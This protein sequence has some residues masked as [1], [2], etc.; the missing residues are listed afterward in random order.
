M[1]LLHIKNHVWETRTHT[2]AYCHLHAGCQ[3]I[4]DRSFNT[5]VW[6]Y[7]PWENFHRGEILSQVWTSTKISSM[8]ETNSP[9]IFHSQASVSFHTVAIFWQFSDVGRIFQS[10]RVCWHRVKRALNSIPMA[11]KS[12]FPF[13]YLMRVSCEAYPAILGSGFRL[14]PH[15]SG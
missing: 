3:S 8:F 13:C 14:L 12:L 4:D 11:Y 6:P 1:H 5:H 2:C 9:G 15:R 10:M 7:I